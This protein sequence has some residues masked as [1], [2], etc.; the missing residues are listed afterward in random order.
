MKVMLIV[1]A[2]NRVANAWRY[3]KYYFTNSDNIWNLDRMKLKLDQ[4]SIRQNIFILTR[5]YAFEAQ[6]TYRGF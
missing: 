4:F 2:N 6:T 5:L 3:F 1:T